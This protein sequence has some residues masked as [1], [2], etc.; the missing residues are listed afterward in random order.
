[1]SLNQEQKNYLEAI[2]EAFN[3]YFNFNIYFCTK[4]GRSELM[5]MYP[6]LYNKWLSQPVS[7]KLP[8]SA[9]GLISEISN[10]Y[11]E[12]EYFAFPYVNPD[13]F[14]RYSNFN[15][16]VKFFTA[17]THPVIGDLKTLLEI[18]TKS[19]R[20]TETEYAAIILDKLYV[21]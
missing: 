12:G 13:S 7:D 10:R 4:S 16:N 20:N 9:A 5:E 14:Y 8:V 1:M 3:A 19:E 2:G 11:S 6:F 15:V 21:R 17:E 18:L